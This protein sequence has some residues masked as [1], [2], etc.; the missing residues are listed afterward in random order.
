V[1][2]IP[3]VL[4]VRHMRPAHAARSTIVRHVCVFAPMRANAS[5]RVHP[6]L[7][8]LQGPNM[9]I[10]PPGSFTFFHE[11]GFGTVDSGHQSLAGLNEV[12]ML[13]RI[14]DHALKMKAMNTLKS[15]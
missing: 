11:D 10:T 7:F 14:E 2:C 4:C 8:L 5:P 3:A 12:V 1:R 6:C 15:V 9:Y 13:S